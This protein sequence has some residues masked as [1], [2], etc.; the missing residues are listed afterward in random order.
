MN[1]TEERLSVGPDSDMQLRPVAHS[2]IRAVGSMAS[3]RGGRGQRKVATLQ[4]RLQ[5]RDRCLAHRGMQQTRVIRSST[6]SNLRLP[7]YR[8]LSVVQPYLEQVRTALSHPP[9]LD[10]PLHDT[11]IRAAAVERVLL[12][13]R[14]SVGRRL[15]PGPLPARRAGLRRDLGPPAP[16]LRRGREQRQ[17]GHQPDEHDTQRDLSSHRPASVSCLVWQPL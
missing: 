14:R 12:R 5:R 2:C 8:V 7:C 17:P 13:S 10:L 16:P 3:G 1:A 4:N 9:A 11:M 6:S 15:T